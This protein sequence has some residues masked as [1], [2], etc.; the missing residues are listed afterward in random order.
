MTY[1]SGIFGGI[2][3]ATLWASPAFA[4]EMKRPEWWEVIA[5][6]IAI[7]TGL[8]GLVVSY[9]TYKKTGLESKKLELEILEKEKEFAKAPPPTAEQQR[10]ADVIIK[11]LIDNTRVNYFLLRFILLSLMLL[12]W[13]ILEK[14]FNFF[15]GGAFVTLTQLLGFSTLRATIPIF[16][17]SQ[18]AQ[19]GWVILVLMVGVPLYRDIARHIGFRVSWRHF[20][21]TDAVSGGHE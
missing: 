16:I 3:L 12:F 14:G 11:P 10:V 4:D 6:I 20:S 1:R 21:T 9:A 19:L 8:L 5:G 13:A 18:L 2:C 17:L 15:V 7:P